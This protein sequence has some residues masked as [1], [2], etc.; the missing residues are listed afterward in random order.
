MDGGEGLVVFTS[1]RTEEKVHQCLG[2]SR[3]PNDSECVENGYRI[4]KYNVKGA[5]V[6]ET[7]IRA[8][9]PIARAK[10]LQQRLGGCPL[11]LFCVNTPSSGNVHTIN[12]VADVMSVFQVTLT[13]RECAD[14]QK[15]FDTHSR[16]SI[17]NRT[18][19]NSETQEDAEIGYSDQFFSSMRA[20]QYMPP[21]DNDLFHGAIFFT[22]NN[23]RITIVRTNSEEEEDQL[24]Q[25]I[26]ASLRDSPTL[27]PSSEK[28]RRTTPPSWLS[29][30]KEP[31]PIMTGAPSCITCH[32]HR[33]S[34]C[35]DCGHQVM[36]DLC[37]RQMCE[38]PGVRR[39][40]PVCRC[41]SDYILRPVLS[42]V[43]K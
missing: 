41:E 27:G 42:E 9:D 22:P 26:E 25:A 40:C 37:V 34:I 33:A 15:L 21:P 28:K 30:L 18:F 8:S 29:I 11:Y 4:Q 35:F 12:S 13:A 36:C 16:G 2:F 32:A 10:K 43:E 38:L 20:G 6:R 7:V 23:N 1:R 19:E 39:A 14:L 31:E 24:R 3:V 17:T 5:V